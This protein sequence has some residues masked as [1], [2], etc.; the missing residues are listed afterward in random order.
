M[1]LYCSRFWAVFSLLF[2]ILLCCLIH[3]FLLLCSLVVFFLS[4]Y[5]YLLV[6]VVSYSW[7]FTGLFLSS[8]YLLPVVFLSFSCHLLPH[9]WSLSFCRS[10]LIVFLLISYRISTVFVFHIVF[11]SLSS[12]RL[13]VIFLSSFCHLSINR[14]VIFL[15]FSCHLSVIFLQSLSCRPFFFLSSCHLS[16]ILLSSKCRIPVVIFSSFFWHR[17]VVLVSSFSHLL[18][19]SLL[20]ICPLFIVFL[21]YYSRLPVVCLISS[22]CLSVVSWSLLVVFPTFCCRLQFFSFNR[23]PIILLSYLRCLY[24]LFIFSLLFFLSFPSCSL[25]VKLLSFFY[26]LSVVSRR[27]LI[28]LSFCYSPVVTFSTLRLSVLF[29]R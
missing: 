28:I 1:F 9:S 25:P 26:S 2:S 22:C 13:P 11:L 23:F 17:P 6:I 18:P 29:L 12:Y 8:A 7:C 16:I 24:N 10:H 21:S 3:L 4:F 20:S 19:I 14:L 27:I 15:L 5:W